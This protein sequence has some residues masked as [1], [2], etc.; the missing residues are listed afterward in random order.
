[1]ACA[2]WLVQMFSSAGSFQETHLSNL[3]WGKGQPGLGCIGR[4]R[5][6]GGRFAGSDGSGSG[7]Y[8]GEGLSVW[9]RRD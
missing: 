6:R 1:M 9:S 5:Q 4:S 7:D 2:L 3:R 8:V